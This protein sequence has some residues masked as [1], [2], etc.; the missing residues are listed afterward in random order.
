MMQM[1]EKMSPHEGIKPCMKKKMMMMK[2]TLSKIEVEVQRRRDAMDMTLD[3]FEGVGL[4]CP[5][6]CTH[7]VSPR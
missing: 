2:L 7:L 6:T 1:M 3:V 5:M 4:P